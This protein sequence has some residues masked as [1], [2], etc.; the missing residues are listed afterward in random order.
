MEIKNIINIYRAISCEEKISIEKSLAFIPYADHMAG[1]W[2]AEKI[3]DAAK[4]GRL[5]LQLGQETFLYCFDSTTK[6]H[7]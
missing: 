7:C 2:F 5:F 6:T 1:K 4:W 3:D